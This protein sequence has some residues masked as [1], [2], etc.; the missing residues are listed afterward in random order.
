MTVEKEQKATTYT[1]QPLKKFPVGDHTIQFYKS[2]VSNK[3]IVTT[4]TPTTLKPGI[5]FERDIT[6]D[7][8]V[9]Y[10]FIHDY[11]HEKV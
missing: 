4:K 6:P 9:V 10:Q 3:L 5:L 8:M 1:Y 7:I 2:P 11:L